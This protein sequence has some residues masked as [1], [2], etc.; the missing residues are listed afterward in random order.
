[1]KRIT[2]EAS[3]DVLW[4]KGTKYIGV[5]KEGYQV[6]FFSEIEGIISNAYLNFQKLK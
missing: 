4:N 1:M 6:E 3:E 2:K 5:S